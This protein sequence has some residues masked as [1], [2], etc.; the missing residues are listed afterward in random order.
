ME[1]A[2]EGKRSRRAVAVSD[3]L[4]AA[5]GVLRLAEIPPANKM[6]IF[7]HDRLYT[8]AAQSP[9]HCDR[10]L[11]RIKRDRIIIA[12]LI[13][14]IAALAMAGFLYEYSRFTRFLDAIVNSPPG[15]KTPDVP[16]VSFVAYLSC[17]LSF[18]VLVEMGMFFHTDACVR[19][20]LILQGQQ[21][22]TRSAYPSASG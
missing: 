6:T 12:I 5:L 19:M 13:L 14:I 16:R 18:T 20:L 2:R 7:R 21:K 10:L 15:S 17:M 11:K 3:I 4:R 1:I 22:V 9:E 8:E